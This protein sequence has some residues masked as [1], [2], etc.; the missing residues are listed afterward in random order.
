MAFLF[1]IYIDDLTAL[2]NRVV[3]C[4]WCYRVQT[5]VLSTSLVQCAIEHRPRFSR[6]ALSSRARLFVHNYSHDDMQASEP[7]VY[8]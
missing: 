3:N 4:T 6:Y 1:A 7:Y 2:S 8:K 5:T